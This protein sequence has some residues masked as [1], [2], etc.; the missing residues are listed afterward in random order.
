MY[1]RLFFFFNL[2]TVSRLAAA[3]TACACYGLVKVENRCVRVTFFFVVVMWYCNRRYNKI[4]VKIVGEREP[5]LFAENAQVG[6][7]VFNFCIH[8]YLAFLF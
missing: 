7:S 6:R 2:S 8:V 4:I 1:T 3:R 5:V